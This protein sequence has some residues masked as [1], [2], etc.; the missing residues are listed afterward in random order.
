MEQYYDVD[1][2]HV[3]YGVVKVKAKNQ[4]EAITKVRQATGSIK[5]KESWISVDMEP[6]SA[7]QS[8]ASLDKEIGEEE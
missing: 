4:E 6:L 7:T 3:E 8:V 2:R 5:M 1:V